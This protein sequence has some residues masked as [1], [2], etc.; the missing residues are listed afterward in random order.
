MSTFSVLKKHRIAASVSAAIIVLPLVAVP[1]TTTV[2]AASS[3]TPSTDGANTETP[4]NAAITTQMSEGSVAPIVSADKPAVVTIISHMTGGEEGDAASHGSMRGRPQTPFDQFFQQFFGPNGP[5]G[6]PNGRNQH[7]QF[8]RSMPFQQQPQKEMEALGSGFIIDKN[9]TIVTNNHVVDGGTDIKVILD[10]GTELPGKVLGRDPKSDLAVVKVEARHDLPVVAWG[11]SEDL[12]L[13]DQILAIGNPFGVGTTVTGG[14]VSARGRDLNGGPYDDFIQVDAPINTGNSGGP[15]VAM[16][17]KVVG[18]DSAIYSPNGGNVG[19]GFAIPS[20]EARTIVQKLIDHGSIEHGFIGVEIQPVTTDIQNALGLDTKDGAL[21]ASVGSDTPA[22]KA[23][24]KAGDIVTAVGD[25]QV[26]D[27]RSLARAVAD[28]TPGTRTEMKVLRHGDRKSL[29]VTI[30]DMK[31]SGDVA[32]ND[33]DDSGDDQPNSQTLGMQLSALTAD[34]RNQLNLP[35][36]ATGVLVEDVDQ[37]SA[38]SDDGVQPG[39]VIVSVNQKPVKSPGDVDEAVKAASASGRKQVLLLV[40]RGENSSF[41]AL[42][43][44]NG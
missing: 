39:D 22:G 14:I 28:L 9:G 32:S 43:L 25:K 42:P 10:D 15:L 20:D 1:V 11:D 5:N 16:N 27:A 7:G 21:V 34:T 26:T 23:G 33:S 44:D 17:G 40:G 13:G 8:G 19:V 41:V 24:V 2:F 38:A 36:D 30:G 35:D 12:K 4:V 6:G 37:N 18:I 3:E 31:N 29:D